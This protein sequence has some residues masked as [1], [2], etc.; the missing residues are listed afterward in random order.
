MPHQHGKG[1]GR[2]MARVTERVTPSPRHYSEHPQH[3]AQGQHYHEEEN[4]QFYE[5]GVTDEHEFDY[6]HGY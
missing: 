3:H 1:R 4:F 5:E 6:H 2:V